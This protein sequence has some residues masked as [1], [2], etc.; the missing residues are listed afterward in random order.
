VLNSDTPSAFGE[1]PGAVIGR[2]Y[3][4]L[5]K[6]ENLPE[7]STYV[8]NCPGETAIPELGLK[9]VCQKPG[10]VINGYLVNVQGSL[11]LRSREAGDTIRLPGGTKSLKKLMI[12]KKIP[13]PQRNRIPVISDERGLLG[14]FGAGANLDRLTGDGHA[15]HFRFVETDR[16]DI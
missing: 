6:L 3:D 14:V 11:I 15:V 8:L 12:D 2:Q 13:A 16:N 5:V 9:V 4:R 10:E 1:F 7:L